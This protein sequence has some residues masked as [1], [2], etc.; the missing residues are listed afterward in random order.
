MQAKRPPPDVGL[1]GTVANVA[2]GSRRKL[3]GVTRLAGASKKG[4]YRAAFDDGFTAIIYIWDESE[5]YWPA[6]EA[7]SHG[8]PFAHASGLEL[9]TSAHLRL[10][11]LGVRAP[12]LYLA[13]ASRAH[14]PAEVALVEDLAGPSLEELLHDDIDRAMVVVR[15][16]GEA[17][18]ALH[19]DRAPT[20]GK[21]LHVNQRGAAAPEQDE[22]VA[23]HGCL[24]GAAS[25]EQIVLARALA[26]LAE[27]SARVAAIS[28]ASARLEDSLRI[29]AADITPRTEFSLIHGE[30]GPD[31]VLV[32]SRDRPVVIDIEGLMY[33]DVEWEDVF[34]RLRFGANYG[35]L[36]APGLDPLRLEL[37]K[38]A[39]HLSLV[40]GPLRLLDGDFP[41]REPMMQIVE[42][43]IA[44]ALS[45]P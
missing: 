28:A 41:D 1:L 6:S 37:Y 27:A 12:T 25:C 15:Q 8:D 39:M 42:S 35:P 16:L 36:Q 30:L 19:S 5:D 29:S 20:M 2:F 10:S 40:A 7:R 4:V 38:L 17:L 9:F 33:F 23:T 18:Q 13:D 31:H 21:L 44:Q 3:A 34:L 22:L 26:D 45:A 14:Y 43:N 24:A 32:D 11:N